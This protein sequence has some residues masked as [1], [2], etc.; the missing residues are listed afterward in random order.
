MKMVGIGMILACQH[1]ADYHSA[2]TSADAFHFLHC[3]AL[4]SERCEGGG[5]LTR[6]QIEIDIASEPF[7]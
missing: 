2:Q 7:I 3:V 1:F 6:A 5:K 4:K